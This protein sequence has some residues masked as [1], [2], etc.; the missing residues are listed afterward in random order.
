M[1]ILGIDMGQKRIGLAISDKLGI[2]AQGLT[3]IER[4]KPEADL[5]QLRQIILENKITKIVVGLPKN[6]NGSLGPQVNKV[7]DF[8]ALLNHECPLE[9]IYWDERLTT[10]EAQRILIEGNLSRK[11]R[12]KV[13]DKLAAVIILQSYLDSRV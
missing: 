13:I 1:R 4:G 9:I 5:C 7:K 12:K 11:K 8:I 2:T 10:I 6:M 3:V